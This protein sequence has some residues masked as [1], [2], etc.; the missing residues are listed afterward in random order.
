MKRSMLCIMVAIIF[1]LGCSEG[2]KG[3]EADYTIKVTGSDKLAFSG[4]Y[5]IAGPG[6][7]P[8]PVQIKGIVPLEYTGKGLAAA[9]IIR[10]TTAEGK[11]KVEILKGR[12]VVS[13]SEVDTPF[14][15]ITLGKIPDAQSIINKIIGMVLG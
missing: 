1:L 2:L 10:K 5:T 7:I 13:A 3:V 14:G 12:N 15:M 11:L 9:C 6:A 4:H 8:K